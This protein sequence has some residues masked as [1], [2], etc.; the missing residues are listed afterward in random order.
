MRFETAV[1]IAADPLR[2]WKAW[3]EVETWPEWTASVS[4]V[5]R[6]DDTEF[7]V[8]SRARLKQPGLRAL[9]WTV[10]E[11]EPGRSFVWRTRTSGIDL[12]AGHYLEDGPDLRVH[13][14]LT[15]EQSGLLAVPVG[16]FVSG[17]IR[18]FMQMEADGIKKRCE[19]D[20]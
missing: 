12:I 19:Q 4:W 2:I 18:K 11:S 8:G 9:V 7:G 5:E 20:A 3:T 13:A 14:R 10:S 17:T 6:L 1:D 15:F 16:I